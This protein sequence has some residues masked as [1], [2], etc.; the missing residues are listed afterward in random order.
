MKPGC[1]MSK[2]IC[3]F[4]IFFAAALLI[5]PYLSTASERQGEFYKIIGKFSSGRSVAETKDGYIVAGSIRDK[6][7]RCCLGWVIKIDKSGTRLWEKTLGEN[8]NDYN[9]AKVIVIGNELVLAGATDVYYKPEWHGGQFS[10][11]RVWAVKL[12]SGG[13]VEWEKRL[14]SPEEIADEKADVFPAVLATDVKAVNGRLIIS[15]FQEIGVYRIPAIWLLDAKGEVLLA[16]SID[17]EKGQST[18]ADRVYPLKNGDFLIAGGFTDHYDNSL[19]TWLARI[20]PEGAVQW[21]KVIETE[22]GRDDEG[23]SQSI[24]IA[25]SNEGIIV[26]AGQE[27]LKFSAADK[28]G[29]SKKAPVVS[30]RGTVWLNKFK[31][32]GGLEWRVKIEEPNICNIKSLWTTKKQDDEMVAAGE[33][34]KDEKGRVW[35]AT[36]SAS[37]R[38]KSIKKLFP[39]DGVSVQQI[40]PTDDRGLIA[41]GVYHDKETGMPSTWIYRAEF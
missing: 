39:A 13:A 17:V 7:G 32:D 27:Y 14:K 19:G 16:R 23:L 28:T 22:K 6:V 33:T 30:N 4:Y 2:N 8:Y 29:F 15:G 40:I 1:V 3:I 5:L 20:S 38:V 18:S 26:G 25:E 34:C 21:E 41:V 24:A 35:V 9:F 11:A 36:L 37:G 31:K 10:S 12:D